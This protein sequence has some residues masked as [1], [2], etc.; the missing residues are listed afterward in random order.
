VRANSISANRVATADIFG[1]V[2]ILG[3]NAAKSAAQD[4]L[5]ARSASTNAVAKAGRNGLV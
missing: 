4:L 3:L 1:V 5:S 2:A